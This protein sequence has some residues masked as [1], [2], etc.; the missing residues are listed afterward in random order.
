MSTCSLEML[1]KLHKHRRQTVFITSYYRNKNPIVQYTIFRYVRSP[2][3]TVLQRLFAIKVVHAVLA[4]KEYYSNVAQQQQIVGQSLN[5]TSELSITRNATADENNKIYCIRSNI[6][7][8]IT[9]F[10]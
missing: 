9:I 6:M 3:L 7:M 4:S 10:N 5:L 2:Y 8:C 1:L